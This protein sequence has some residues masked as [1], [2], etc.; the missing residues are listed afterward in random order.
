MQRP[1]RQHLSQLR[2]VDL[3]HLLRALGHVLAPELVDDP[4]DRQRAIGVDEQ[5]RE[6]RALLAAAQP[7]LALP[8]A[9]LERSEDPKVHHAPRRATVPR[10][11]RRFTG[12]L[13][14]SSRR[15]RLRVSFAARPTDRR[16][17]TRMTSHDTRGRRTGTS[18]PRS[19]TRP[20][21]RS[22]RRPRSSSTSSR[23]APAP[24]STRPTSSR[25]STRG[26]GRRPTGRSSTRRR[27]PT[28]ATSS[29][30]SAGTAARRP[31][32]G[33]DR[34]HLI[35]P[36]LPLLAGLRRQRRRR[37]AAAADREGDRARRDPAR[38]RL[39]APAH[40]A[41]H[42]GRER[43]HLDARRRRRQ[44]R[45]RL[46]RRRREDVRGEGALGER[47]AAAADELR[48]LVPAAQE[49]ARLERVRRPERVRARLRPR[50]RRGRPLRAAAP[51]LEPRA[52]RARA[53]DRPRRER[54]R[55]AR[56]PLE[57]RP[58]GGRG[59]R[60]RRAVVRD[61]ALPPRERLRTQR[62]R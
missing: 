34:S 16:K 62:S 17:E 11:R 57:A 50:R 20:P 32:T 43:R 42:A 21:T 44:R 60:R 37:P 53:D 2:D 29:T 27:C 33:P 6:Q 51:L 30:T 15:S 35:V 22:R 59:L 52:P 13:P 56:D 24:A 25:S 40:D 8:V 41:L 26:R 39:H 1:R 10:R 38:D 47:R 9:H 31:A 55:P 49:H 45:R 54:A 19:T 7:D 58:R 4:V 48:L 12:R 3:H 61:L 28:S 14:P 46:R 23:C 5:E 18:P 36:G